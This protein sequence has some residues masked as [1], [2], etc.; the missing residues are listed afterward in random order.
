M[1]NTRFNPKDMN[2]EIICIDGKDIKVKWENGS[3]NYYYES[4]LKLVRRN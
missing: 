4:D 1:I 3:N 2:G